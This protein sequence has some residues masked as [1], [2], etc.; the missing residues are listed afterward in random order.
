MQVMIKCNWPGNV[1]ELENCVERSATMTR[2]EV[3]R[4]LDL[5]CQHG[6]C[7]SLVLQNYGQASPPATIPI[8]PI[9]FAAP[10]PASGD[11]EPAGERERL[12]Q[13]MEQSGWVQAKA[14][15]L[16]HL[17]PRQIGYALKKYNIPLK[18]F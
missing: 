8:V 1:R 18:R 6:K 11:V 7:F 13:A 17:T 2:G 12:I 4:A 3:I 14:A 16:L 15:R 10:A 5:P 9:A